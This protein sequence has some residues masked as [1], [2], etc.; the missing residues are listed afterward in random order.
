MLFIYFSGWEDGKSNVYQVLSSIL[1]MILGAEHPYYME[2]DFGGWEGTAPTGPPE[3]HSL[4]VIEY[5]EEVYYG[6]AKWTI[7]EMLKTPPIG[8]EEVVTTHLL[9][10]KKLIL[11]TISSWMKKG[12]KNLKDRLLPVYEELKKLFIIKN[13]SISDLKKELLISLETEKFIIAKTKYIQTKLDLSKLDI[14]QFAINSP[15]AYQ[16][17]LLSPKLLK[18][19]RIEIKEKENALKSLGGSITDLSDVDGAEEKDSASFSQPVQ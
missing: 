4:E 16:R 2:P 12:S 15:K 14:H 5:D 9:S 11:S 6:T 1:W 18:K 13:V 7:L 10:K 17:L 3:M 19:I 8:F